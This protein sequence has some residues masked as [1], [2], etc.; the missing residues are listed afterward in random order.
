MKFNNLTLLLTLFLS[1][2]LSLSCDTTNP[3]NSSLV[4]E[5]KE[6]A[7]T[8]VWLTLKSELNPR[9]INVIIRNGNTPLINILLTT[10]DTILFLDKLKP[11]SNYSFTAETIIDDFYMKSEQINC[12]TLDTT[13]HDFTWETFYFGG[14]IGTYIFED[15]EII[16]ENNIWVVGGFST[17]G[18]DSTWENIHNAIRWDGGK[19][20]I[21]DIRTFYFCGNDTKWPGELMHSIYFDY[22][23]NIWAASSNQI[24]NVT[25]DKAFCMEGITRLDAIQGFD[26]GELLA[27]NHYNGG[28]HLN[29][30]NSGNW[31]KVQTEFEGY[32]TDLLPLRKDNNEK[33]ILFP[34]SNNQ[35]NQYQLFCINSD[36]VIKPYST[37]PNS[38]VKSIWTDKG[39][40]IHVVSGSKLFENKTGIWKEISLLP[41]Q[42]FAKIRGSKL[43]N[44]FA[45]GWGNVAHYNGST[46]KVYDELKGYYYSVAV[47]DNIVVIVGMQN[48]KAAVVMGIKN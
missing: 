37:L 25:K 5:L 10:N 32:I 23:N 8:E 30:F 34:I 9:P 21:S 13:T 24:V 48:N 44:I 3:A 17:E 36:K 22:E 20:N 40:P 26:T 31:G 4:L 39:F 28:S 6:V 43:N 41:N 45:I 46:W 38:F 47:K 2:Y 18:R 29:G 11:M 16:D 7:S 19:W 35:T 27:V 33:I 14:N 12:T 42:T 1:L 15:V